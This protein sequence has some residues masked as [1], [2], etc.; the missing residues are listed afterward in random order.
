MSITRAK[1]LL[2]VIGN[3][4]I[5]QYDGTWSKF[6]QHC[7]NN[8][9]YTEDKIGPQTTR[10][11]ASTKPAKVVRKR[12]RNSKSKQIVQTSLSNPPRSS[13]IIP[14][15]MLPSCGQF[16]NPP[17]MSEYSNGCSG[18]DYKTWLLLGAGANIS[19]PPPIRELWDEPIPVADFS[20]YQ[21][22]ARQVKANPK[23]ETIS[24]S[25]LPTPPRS[26]TVISDVFPF[27]QESIR[28]LKVEPAV[29]STGRIETRSQFLNPQN[30]IA[31]SALSNSSQSSGDSSC[32]SQIVQKSSR[33]LKDRGACSSKS[34]K[35]I[36]P[37]PLPHVRQT[38]CGYVPPRRSEPSRQS[39]FLETEVESDDYDKEFDSVYSF[40]EDSQQNPIRLRRQT[41]PMWL[42]DTTRV[43]PVFRQNL[44]KTEESSFLALVA[45]IIILFII[46][47]ILVVIF[48]IYLRKIGFQ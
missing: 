44:K 30:T 39:Y 16:L 26:S 19:P 20:P 18:L 6:I 11:I 47:Y 12:R 46:F 2:I 4:N 9:A 36:L 21:Y 32:V 7:L 37:T 38:L 10:R 45:K 1:S 17:N 24:R 14:V 23:S 13:T 35:T 40:D 41:P 34:N 43:S 8:K 15:G 31:R 42:R 25:A 3:P 48:S 33:P 5:L 29:C 22:T 27:V 28:P